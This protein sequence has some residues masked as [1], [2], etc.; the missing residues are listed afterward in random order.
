MLLTACA[1]DNLKEITN[2]R[3]LCDGLA[4]KIDELNDSLLIDGGPLTVVAGEK[5]IS[6][7][8]AGCHGTVG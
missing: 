8:D 7:F 3:G 2:E 4:S 5:V 1:R 6:G